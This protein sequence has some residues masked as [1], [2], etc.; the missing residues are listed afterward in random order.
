M[1]LTQMREVTMNK[2]TIISIACV[3]FLLIGLN[4]SAQ[5]TINDVIY[6]FSDYKPEIK[7]AFKVSER[8]TV[9]KPTEKKPDIQ[10]VNQ[11]KRIDT[12]FEVEPISAAKMSG[13]P[14]TKL[15][16]SLIKIGYG[17]YQTPMAEVYFNNGRSKKHSLGFSYRHL[18][19]N[20]KIENVGFPGYSMNLLN[21]N[22]EKYFKN[23]TFKSNISWN[24]N[25]V[26]YYGFDT[27]KFTDIKNDEIKQRFSL[28]EI[29][30]TYYSTYT[31][32][33]KLN[34]KINLNYYNLFDMFKTFENNVSFA[35]DLDKEINLD[36]DMQ[37][38]KIGLLIEADYNNLSNT[39]DTLSDGIIKI[40][41][42][43]SFKA[44]DITI[45]GGVKA[46]VEADT[47]SYLRFFPC[48]DVNLQIAENILMVYGGIDGNVQ[49]NS[50]RSLSTE[51]PFINPLVEYANTR[52]KLYAYFGLKGNIN[53]KISFNANL[54]SH[55]MINMAMYTA[56]T[57]ELLHNRFNVIYDDV[58]YL[59]ASGEIAYQKNEKI[60][61][62]IG[63]EYNNYQTSKEAYAWY[64]PTIAGKIA[65][66]YN[67]QDKIITKAELYY[68]GQTYGKNYDTT[69]NTS[70]R[71]NKAA[72]DFN[73]GIEYRYSKILSAFVNFNNIVAVRHYP[74][75][76][77]PKQ[78]FNLIGGITY[79]F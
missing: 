76:N 27:R 3:T 35:A 20:G 22:A 17:P 58:K 63:G 48:I 52:E 12:K 10:Y 16:K 21:G 39:K 26:H 71:I 69:L 7:D 13:E 28:S 2:K 57:S 74:W 23:H 54:S 4:L 31:N 6:N 60:K 73:I 56:D 46:I 25:V 49:K 55:N 78:K 5:D 61:I 1:K 8:P 34:H 15:Y 29:K 77:Y 14:L 41:P 59:K 65:A 45:K 32:H 42:T 19:S 9:I 37:D 64:K 38:E 79:S 11:P 67:I 30:N 36:A 44:N 70:Y 18:S 75:L 51:N 62:L 24:R 43:V 33:D 40:I 72:F 50:F 68:L 53:S 47:T 66:E